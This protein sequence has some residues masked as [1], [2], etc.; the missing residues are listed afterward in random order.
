MHSFR[1]LGVTS[2]SSVYYVFSMIIWTRPPWSAVIV[3]INIIS[4]SS[5]F[6]FF[7]I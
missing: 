3:I 1:E 6:I 7:F 2:V 5:F 4:S